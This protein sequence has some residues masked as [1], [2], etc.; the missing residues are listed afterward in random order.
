MIRAACAVAASALAASACMPDQ[1]RDVAMY[2]EITSLGTTQVVPA[3]G[4]PLT[5]RDAALL[6]NETSERLAIQGEE[7]VRAVAERRKR[8]AEFLPT[9]DLVP[10][11][12]FQDGNSGGSNVV[13]NSGASTSFDVPVV[14]RVTLFDGFRNVNRLKS[15]DADVENR[16]ALVL[17]LRETLLLDVV[18]TYYTIL[19][20][21]RS[22]K[23]L[24]RSLALQEERLRDIKGRQAAG[25]ARPL[26]VYQTEAQ[27]A[28]TRVA[29][30]DAQNSVAR[31]RE[32]L[33]FVVGAPIQAC[34]L[35]DGFD[36]PAEIPDTSTLDEEAL[37][38][39]QD[40]AAAEA[41]ARAARA[42]VDVAIGQYAPSVS[43]NFDWWLHRDSVPTDRDWA[44]L[45]SMN[46]PIF[47]AGQIEADIQAAWSVFR[48]EVLSYQA[49]KRQVVTDVA[50]ARADVEASRS[51]LAELDV[52][53][54]AAREAY[55]Q[56]DASYQVG[57]AT[58]L[59]RLVALDQQLN[60]ELA[61]ALEV[62]RYRG[63][64]AALLRATGRLTP[65]LSGVDVPLPPPR[66]APESPFI[67]AH[68]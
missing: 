62:F 56:A 53:V 36:V 10:T 45:L 28:S 46:V 15:A 51:R 54:R 18:R 33:A 13:F 21:E 47:T 48:Q 40:L 59:E 66:P 3:Q 2:R 41:A 63:L 5:L 4:D 61:Q 50:V 1:A 58:N 24:E 42:L 64:Y 65:G 35:D 16:R 26:D 55:R 11:F 7:F 19:V 27:V 52:Q 25:V 57:L 49:I 30:L 14:A 23:V 37:A 34:P 17:D 29:L 60:A 68:P 32:L 67:V 22:V 31:G 20:A 12:G 6:A 39:R 43:L 44:G 9:V 38:S 8:V